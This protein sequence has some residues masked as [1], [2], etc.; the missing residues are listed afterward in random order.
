MTNTDDFRLKTTAGRVVTA[1][2]PVICV[3]PM[4]CGPGLRSSLGVSLRGWWEAFSG[5][6]SAAG[7][8]PQWTPRGAEQMDHKG[9]FVRSMSVF[10]ATPGFILH[11]SAFILGFRRARRVTTAHRHPEMPR[12]LRTEEST[13]PAPG[14]DPILVGRRRGFVWLKADS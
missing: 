8:S 2:T 14:S 5:Q 3:N 13:K 9:S 12:S 7:P 10:A 11:P 4:I 1:D 6:R